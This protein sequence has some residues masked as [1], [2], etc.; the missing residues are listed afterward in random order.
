MFTLD[1]HV[2]AVLHGILT[3]DDQH[4]ITTSE[5]RTVKVWSHADGTLLKTFASHRD[6]VNQ[7]AYSSKEQ[8]FISAGNDGNVQIHK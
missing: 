8:V 3:D 6:W 5:D 2:S 4:I 1:D 7:V